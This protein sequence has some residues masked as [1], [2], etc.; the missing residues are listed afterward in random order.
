MNEKKIELHKCLD[1]YIKK[2]KRGSELTI[3]IRKGNS[4]RGGKLKSERS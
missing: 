3:V 2:K 4:R 1:I